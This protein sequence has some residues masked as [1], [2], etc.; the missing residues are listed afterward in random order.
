VP[1]PPQLVRALRQH[2]HAHGTAEDGRL[3]ASPRG[4][5]LHESCYGRAWHAART[6]AL[7]PDLAATSLLRRPYDL[8]H[9]ALSL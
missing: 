9:S 1:I 2:L 5:L 3:F 4:G 7:G 8:R 6:A